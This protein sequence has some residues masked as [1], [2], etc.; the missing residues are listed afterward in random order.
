[1]PRPVGAVV[2]NDRLSGAP[3]EAEVSG[4]R[5]GETSVNPLGE[6]AGVRHGNRVRL[7]R[8]RRRLRVRTPLASATTRVSVE[9]RSTLAVELRP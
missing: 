2:E 9:T 6:M 4:F 7:T 3:I 8:T 5:G 1:M